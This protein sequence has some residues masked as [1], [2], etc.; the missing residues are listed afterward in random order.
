MAN[1]IVALKSQNR[2]IIHEGLSKTTELELMQDD[3]SDICSSS[4]DPRYPPRNLFQRSRQTNATPGSPSKPS[5]KYAPIATV[6]RLC[7]VIPV[8]LS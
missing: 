3:I 6:V 4:Y 1:C 5:V 7:V 8:Y 2:Q